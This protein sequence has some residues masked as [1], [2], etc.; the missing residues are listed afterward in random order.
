[1]WFVPAA[2]DSTIQGDA[3]Y[4]PLPQSGVHQDETQS[5][6]NVSLP[7]WD[8]QGPCEAMAFGLGS[9]EVGSLSP[10]FASVS[11]QPSR[12]NEVQIPGSQSM[13][14][15]VASDTQSVEFEVGQ[16]SPRQF[17]LA[18]SSYHQSR[19]DSYQEFSGCTPPTSFT[20]CSTSSQACRKSLSCHDKQTMPE[21]SH[22][23][24]IFHHCS[25]VTILSSSVQT[26]KLSWFSG[27]NK[28]R[29]VDAQSNACQLDAMHKFSGSR[30]TVEQSKSAAQSSHPQQVSTVVRESLGICASPGMWATPGYHNALRDSERGF[31]FVDHPKQQFS[32]FEESCNSQEY[33]FLFNDPA[34]KPAH[35]LAQAQVPC[36]WT[37]PS[38]SSV[39][40]KSSGGLTPQVAVREK[41]PNHQSRS[42]NSQDP[43]EIQ[44]HEN[45]Q[46]TGRKNPEEKK[47]GMTKNQP[48]C[49]SQEPDKQP[50]AGPPE[51]LK[52]PRDCLS[53]PGIWAT[54]GYQNAH[55]ESEHGPASHRLSTFSCPGIWATPGHQNA[56]PDE[57]VPRMASSSGCPNTWATLDLNCHGAPARVAY[58]R[59]E[60]QVYPHEVEPCMCHPGITA[61]A[62]HV[63]HEHMIVP[64]QFI[65]SPGIWA[66]PGYQNAQTRTLKTNL[67]GHSGESPILLRAE[68]PKRG[69]HQNR[70]QPP[71][72]GYY[73]TLAR[74]G[75]IRRLASGEMFHQQ[76]RSC[77]SQDPAR[78]QEPENSQRTGRQHPE[79]KKS[80]MTQNQPAGRTQ[81]PDKQPAVGSQEPNPDHTDPLSC[82]G[83][84]ATPGYQNA[85]S[86]TWQ[87][88]PSPQDVEVFAKEVE[89][90]EKSQHT[91]SRMDF[92]PEEGSQVPFPAHHASPPSFGIAATPGCQDAHMW[93]GHAVHDGEDTARGVEVDETTPGTHGIPEWPAQASPVHQCSMNLSCP[94]IW[95]TPGHQN[96]QSAESTSRQKVMQVKVGHTK[97]AYEVDQPPDFDVVAFM[98]AGVHLRPTKVGETPA[99]HLMDDP[100]IAAQDNMFDGEEDPDSS[101][102]DSSTSEDNPTWRNFLCLY[103][104]SASSAG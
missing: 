1:M 15:K 51:P 99:P 101:D 8:F 77:N 76:C 23:H 37:H 21:K 16:P 49:R 41:V 63:G 47:S 58:A 69:H 24:T 22:L 4:A 83:I 35:F 96:A 61:R 102:D 34:P 14:Q 48:A 90:L 94:G 72:D 43:V 88:T 42:C 55:Q 12:T 13:P 79:E 75:S 64:N 65:A 70:A 36:Q 104:A 10:L 74:G 92:M 54:P 52:E 103:R 30:P 84:W 57:Q 97:V 67:V 19:Y 5:R 100:A 3:R 81:E 25:P 95:A 68:K 59:P 50:A 87:G 85:H 45:S 56:Q 98:A 91:R 89:A 18:L 27:R 11:A 26:E 86:A 31:H 44:E 20:Q 29:V 28:L 39:E 80:G 62:G 33:P 7:F 6:S 93:S 40:N 73:H 66:T 9:Q 2:A 78:T 46:R 38:A 32:S 53:C 17:C 60:G 71:C 82:P